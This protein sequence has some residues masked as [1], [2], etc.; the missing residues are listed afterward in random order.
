VRLLKPKMLVCVM[1]KS[2]AGLLCAEMHLVEVGI[3]YLQGISNHVQFSSRHYKGHLPKQREMGY[4][5]QQ[6]AN[7]RY[8]VRDPVCKDSPRVNGGMTISGDVRGE[9]MD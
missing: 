2:R 1:L 4:H 9:A 7:L 8:R 5:V 3:C 6:D